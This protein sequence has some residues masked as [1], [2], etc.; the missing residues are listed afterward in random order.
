MP[1]VLQQEVQEAEEEIKVEQK[2]S[3][4]ELATG[5]FLL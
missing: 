4:V 1:E 2:N 5:S 3:L